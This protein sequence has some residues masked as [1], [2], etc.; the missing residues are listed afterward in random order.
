MDVEIAAILYPQVFQFH[1]LSL[2]ICLHQPPLEL[3][4]DQKF[5]T[6]ASFW[7]TA[8]GF[9]NN[10]LIFPSIFKRKT[11]HFL[12]WGYDTT[13]LPICQ[14]RQYYQ[15]WNYTHYKKKQ[16]MVHPLVKVWCALSFDATAI[17]PTSVSFSR[18]STV[19]ELFGRLLLLWQ[20][21]AL[22][23]VQ[24]LECSSAIMF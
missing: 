19:F 7:N 13:Y 17:S 15:C 22:Q 24:H 9:K 8:L 21:L 20:I 23:N 6:F 14:A 11:I 2:R 5:S 3:L 10:F 18:Q 12:Q 1:E 4:F 16:Q